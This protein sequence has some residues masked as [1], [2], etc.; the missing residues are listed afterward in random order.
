MTKSNLASFLLLIITV[1]FLTAPGS[2]IDT[3]TEIQGVIDRLTS[4]LDDA[5]SAM[6]A[7]TAAKDTYQSCIV[8]ANKLLEDGNS[9]SDLKLSNIE[10]HWKVLKSEVIHN[11]DRIFGSGATKKTVKEYFEDV[12]KE[13]S[14]FKSSQTEF[15]R[16]VFYQSLKVCHSAYVK[17]IEKGK[18]VKL[19]RQNVETVLSFKAE[20]FI[21]PAKDML[22]I[23][24]KQ[25]HKFEKHY[26]ELAEADLKVKRGGRTRLKKKADDFTGI[27][28]RSEKTSGKK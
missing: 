9:A 6:V 4:A 14:A 1:E 7:Y 21:E 2:A 16:F 23:E 26:K 11:Y 24:K 22:E 19:Y 20:K 27:F 13:G 17:E 18:D 28:K 25:A 5:K 8:E 10:T 12:D 3:I 15:R